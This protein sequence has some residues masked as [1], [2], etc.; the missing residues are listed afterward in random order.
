MAIFDFRQP[1]PTTLFLGRDRN[2]SI[3]NDIESIS[4]DLVLSEDHTLPNEVTV[5]NI[6][7]G[8]II[9][10]NI[11]LA[12]RT[13]SLVGFVTNF[14]VRRAT[15]LFSNYPFPKNRAQEAFDALKRIRDSRQLVTLVTNLEIYNDVAITGISAGR[16]SDDGESQSFSIS[17]QEARVV[18]LR[19]VAIEARVN[20][21][22]LNNNRARQA[23]PQSNVGRTTGT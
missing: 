13:G 23:S 17:F 14:S 3:K 20:P 16:S 5:Y 21:G 4:F 11:R 8:S 2:F 1:L 6:E 12:L 9:T 10:D 22:N 18:Q 7:D 15:S 19:T